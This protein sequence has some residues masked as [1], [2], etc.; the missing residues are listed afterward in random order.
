MVKVCGLT[1][2]EDL[3][4]ARALGAWATGFVFAPSP[5]R[6]TPAAARELLERATMASRCVD[7]AAAA[8]PLTVG[9]FTDAPA[10]EIA[11]VVREVGLDAVQ[12][13]GLC[14]CGGNA[15]RAA[16]AGHDR[17]VLVIQA[18]P[19]DHAAGEADA[20]SPAVAAAR[21]EADIVLLDTKTAGRFGGSGKTFPWRLARTVAAGA[22]L[23]VAGGIGPDNVQAALRESG[24]WGVDVSSGIEKSRGVKDAA[25]MAKLFANV[26][27]M[28]SARAWA[29]ARTGATAG[30]G[31]M[32][33]PDAAPP[34]GG[35][36]RSQEG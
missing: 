2:L 36:H 19:V 7:G 23:L 20:L 9:V 24:A 13:H 10:D 26:G 35:T 6:L 16:L 21:A 18:V 5:R 28:V 33:P 14:A 34:T 29:R 3:L 4:L 17:P 12:L 8:P 31:A 30:A 22:P 11:A 1:R 27:A 32:S 15:V 25:R